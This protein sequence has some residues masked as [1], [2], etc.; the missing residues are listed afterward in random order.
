MKTI[1][2]SIETELHK[3][4]KLLARQAGRT[5]HAEILDA[6]QSHIANHQNAAILAESQLGLRDQGQAGS[7][8]APMNPPIRAP[9]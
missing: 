4:M 7:T 5:L 3:S 6:L 2:A 8:V 9:F 1:S